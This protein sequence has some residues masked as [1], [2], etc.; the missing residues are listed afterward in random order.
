MNMHYHILYQHTA[1]WIAT[2]VLRD[3][4]A[5]FLCNSW[6]LFI[7][8]WGCWYV[9]MSP[10]DKF[11]ILGWPLRPVGLSLKVVKAF[12][13]LPLIPPWKRECIFNCLH[14]RM[15]CY[16]FGWNW[17]QK[18]FEKSRQF[19]WAKCSGYLLICYNVR[20][21]QHNFKWP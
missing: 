18:N 6:F 20:S 14:P 8:W 21:N 3:Y 9:N 5:A 13:L 17:P 1:H 15:L 12:P 4:N 2:I 19:R 7:L 10:S 16:K 11:L